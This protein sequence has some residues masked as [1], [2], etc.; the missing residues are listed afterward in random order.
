MPFP[1]T[2]L[3]DFSFDKEIMMTA[4]YRT[5]HLFRGQ[6]R[7]AQSA[8]HCTVFDDGDKKITNEAVVPRKP[9]NFSKTF[10]EGETGGKS[11]EYRQEQTERHSTATGCGTRTESSDIVGKTIDLME[12][13][14]SDQKTVDE[15]TALAICRPLEVDPT[16]KPLRASI[17]N[18]PMMPE[19]ARKITLQDFIT[20]STSSTVSDKPKPHPLKRWTTATVMNVSAVNVLHNSV[21]L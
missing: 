7:K 12:E 1:E 2:D 20:L 11:T 6:R 13:G 5:V 9:G 18:L 3:A 4:V 10:Q 8:A 15:S 17:T 16:N 21:V 14:V 19:H